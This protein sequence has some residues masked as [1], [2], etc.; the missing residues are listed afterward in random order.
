MSA[1]PS[2]AAHLLAQYYEWPIAEA[3][4]A[5]NLSIAAFKQAL[6]DFGIPE[7]PGGRCPSSDCQCS[8]AEPLVTA[9]A[10]EL[11]GW[12]DGGGVDA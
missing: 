12:Q 9:R 8:P 7:H 1:E 6:A 5:L 11:L 10:Y 2:R 4:A 3:T